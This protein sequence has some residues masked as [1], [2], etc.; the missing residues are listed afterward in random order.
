MQQEE[1]DEYW[2]IFE[3]RVKCLAESDQRKLAYEFSSLVKKNLDSLGLEALSII[4]QLSFK[5]VALKT[6]EKMQKR[7][8]EKLPEDNSV[9][10]YSV[11]IWTLQP[12]TDSYPMWYAAGIA[13]LNLPDLKIA[14]LPE[15][16]KLTEKTLERLQTKSA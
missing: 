4:E 13:G 6:C 14:T 8:Q 10:P 7:L 11:L 3:T 1:L 15:L 5:K 2:N 9:S 16:T 12:H